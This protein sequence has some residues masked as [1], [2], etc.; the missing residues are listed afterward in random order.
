MR[1]RQALYQLSYIPSSWPAVFAAPVSFRP[2]PRLS[3]LPVALSGCF[4]CISGHLREPLCLP[5]VQSAEHLALALPGAICMKKMGRKQAEGS[6]VV[7]SVFIYL[8][9]ES[10]QGCQ[11]KVRGAGGCGD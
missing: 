6:R 5:G 9:F 7:C 2:E 4:T 10:P 8:H 1:A 11:P 3:F